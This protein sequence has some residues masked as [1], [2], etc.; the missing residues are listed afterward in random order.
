[1]FNVRLYAALHL[2]HYRTLSTVT[3]IVYGLLLI[4]SVV[5]LFL[6]P[7]AT[8]TIFGSWLCCVSIWICIGLPLDL[9]LPINLLTWIDLFTCVFSS[10]KGI[11]LSFPMLLLLLL[12]LLLLRLPLLLLCWVVPTG[13][14]LFLAF[15]EFGIW[16]QCLSCLWFIG[17]SSDFSFS[18]YNSCVL[19]FFPICLCISNTFV[20]FVS[21]VRLKEKEFRC[22]QSCTTHTHIHQVGHSYHCLTFF[23][24][25]ERFSLLMWSKWIY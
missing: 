25:T 20:T 15:S 12:L 22:R 3:I 16:W 21:N 14:V 18:L 13:S 10:G 24:V 7:F 1:M 19:L 2:C 11:S 4:R 9:L 5:N 6:A 8:T 17:F 23:K